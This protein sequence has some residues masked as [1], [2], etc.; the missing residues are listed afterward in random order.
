MKDSRNSQFGSGRLF[1]T[2]AGIV[3]VLCLLLAYQLLTSDPPEPLRAWLQDA[4][5]RNALV[6]ALGGAFLVF[7]LGVGLLFS[8]RRAVDSPGRRIGRGVEPDPPQFVEVDQVTLEP[9]DPIVD[10]DLAK[11]AAERQQLPA[12]RDH[13]DSTLERLQ[14]TV[15]ETDAILQGIDEATRAVADPDSPPHQG[16]D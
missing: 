2:F 10:Q 14:A 12:S 9:L 11:W 7:L 16:R 15:H 5:L 1:T 8:I 6:L 3:A 13:L 4:Q